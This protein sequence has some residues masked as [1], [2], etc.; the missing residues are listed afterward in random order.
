MFI[1][2]L[3]ARART[4]KQH[5]CPLMEKWIKKMYMYAMKYYKVIKNNKIM[6]CAAIWMELEIVI[7][8]EV[9]QTEMRNIICYPL[10]LKSKK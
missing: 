5:K 4:W 10:Y 3:F 6:S 7:L 8:T 1:A 9:N 2:T